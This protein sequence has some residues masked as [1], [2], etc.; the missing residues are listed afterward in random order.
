MSVLRWC[1]WHASVMTKSDRVDRLL[2]EV[3]KTLDPLVPSARRDGI[4]VVV[5]LVRSDGTMVWQAYSVG[6]DV[7]LAA[8]AAEQRYLVEE[9]GAGSV[10]GV[11][12]LDKAR[13]RAG[14]SLDGEIPAT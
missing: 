2:A 11:S 8:L 6:P 5:D 9:V 4:G 13:E 10:P 14:R 1:R 3:A 7:V 12:Y